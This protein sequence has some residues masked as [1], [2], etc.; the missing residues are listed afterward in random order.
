VQH[1]G[2]VWRTDSEMVK[3]RYLNRE[4]GH[5]RRTSQVGLQAFHHI[6]EVYRLERAQDVRRA[7]RLVLFLVCNLLCSARA[8]Y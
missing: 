7:H 3:G 5:E 2:E 6:P 8:T 4:S 1:E